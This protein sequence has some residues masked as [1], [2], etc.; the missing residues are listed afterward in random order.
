MEIEE[1]LSDVPKDCRGFRPPL[2][3]IYGFYI[4]S[5]CKTM[6]V[7]E[8]CPEGVLFVRQTYQIT[9]VHNYIYLDDSPFVEDEL[10]A[11]A[12]EV[13]FIKIRKDG[14]L[15]PSRLIDK[16]RKCSV[17]HVFYGEERKGLPNEYY[18]LGHEDV[19]KLSI[20]ENKSEWLSWYAINTGR[21]PYYR[22]SSFD[23]EPG[24]LFKNETKH[25]KLGAERSGLRTIRCFR[26]K[27]FYLF[28]MIKDINPIIICLF[29]EYENLLGTQK[30]N[31][32][33]HSFVHATVHGRYLYV[34]SDAGIEAFDIVAE[35]PP[36]NVKLKD[37]NLAGLRFYPNTLRSMGILSVPG[38]YKEN[39][40]TFFE[41]S[42][43][44]ILISNESLYSVLYFD[45]KP[46]CFS[47]LPEGLQGE[48]IGFF[49]V[50]KEYG[51]TMPRELAWYLLGFLFFSKIRL[52]QRLAHGNILKYL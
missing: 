16:D 35:Y 13:V 17:I 51:I 25:K 21:Y 11:G 5:V 27:K 38:G 33:I 48:V 8:K 7:F 12:E 36:S 43:K 3:H 34:C 41:F 49:S 42:R 9:N 19:L 24:W 23:E 37:V 2:I 15:I 50:L 6:F 18:L 39:P 1:I 40:T 44:E 28:L 10:W 29:D 45:P 30:Y 47:S 52:A 31:A 22:Y 4:F 46:G 32:G 20:K 14:M 26:T